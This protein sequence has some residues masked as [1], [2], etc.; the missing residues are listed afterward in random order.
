MVTWVMG[1]IVA[2]L[3]PIST[4][5][6]TIKTFS[7]IMKRIVVFLLRYKS[8][9]FIITTYITPIVTMNNLVNRT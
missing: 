4:C 7:T 3:G 1:V 5:P 8:T 2:V 9:S 6:I